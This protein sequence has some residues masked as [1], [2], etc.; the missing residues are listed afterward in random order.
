LPIALAASG[1]DEL[2]RAGRAAVEGPGAAPSAPAESPS[3]EPAGAPRAPARTPGGDAPALLGTPAWEGERSA[4][5]EDIA[6]VLAEERVEGVIVVHDLRTGATLRSDSAR[7]VRAFDPAGTFD[8]AAALIALETGAVSGAF[9]PIDP[10]EGG[11][12]GE[13][14]DLATAFRRSAS[15]LTQELVRRIGTEAT[16]TWVR[17]IG[18]GSGE[19][20]GLAISPDQQ[21]GFLRRLHGG[22]L[23]FSSRAQDAVRELMV[24]DGGA[25]WTLRGKTGW[26]RVGPAD[27][28]WFVGWVERGEEAAFFA[29]EFENTIPARDV[30]ALRERIYRRTLTQLGLVPARR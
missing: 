4:V 3:E 19:L 16:Q 9:A 26:Q 13:A 10:P 8:I 24:L 15:W 22:Q 12:S 20:D 28:L 30:Q 1:C 21:I 23:P 27:R 2:I 18:Y 17:Q 5:A 6:A 14:L 11:Q 25:G 29:I 7:A